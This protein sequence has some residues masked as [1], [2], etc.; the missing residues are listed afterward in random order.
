MKHM[1]GTATRSHLIGMAV[2][3]GVV[4]LGLLAWG[5]PA[6]AAAGWAVA[7]ACPL[8]MIGMMA[9]MVVGRKRHHTG[10]GTD[11]ARQ[12]TEERPISLTVGE[13]R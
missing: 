11:E 5:V 1:N 3:A 10:N 7:L 13:G 2:T 12:A 9:F 6:G 8:M 4:G